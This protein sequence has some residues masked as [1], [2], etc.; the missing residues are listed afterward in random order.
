MQLLPSL[1][2]DL[3]AV[4]AACPDLRKGR[5]GNN[6][7]RRFRSFG[8]RDVFYAERV[9]SGLSAHYGKRPSAAPIVRRYSASAGFPPTITSAIFSTRHPALL[10]PCFERMEALLC[11]PPMRQAFGRLDGR[12]LVAWDGTE[13]FC[14]QKLGCPHC[15]D[16]QALQR[17]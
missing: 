9:V 1:L 6:C 16:A 8:L 4:C 17:H 13:F 2:S 10:Q 11:K 14:S 5:G 15:P 7:A 12:T 3:K